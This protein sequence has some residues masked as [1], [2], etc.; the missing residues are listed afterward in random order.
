[1][2]MNYQKLIDFI[3]RRQ[4]L[5]LWSAIILYF[6]VFS[7]ICL[8]KYYH[9]GYNGLDLAIY[10]QVFYNSAHGRLFEFS[11][12]PQSYLGD[13]FELIII[14]LLPF[15]YF[16]QHPVNLL[17]IQSLML[18]LCA[19]PLY[20]IAKKFLSVRWSLF[21]AWAWLLCPFVQN[22]NLFEFHILP[23][24]IF[25][26]LWAWYF[27][28]KNN[29]PAFIALCLISLLVREDVALVVF[30]FGL[31]AWLEKRPWRWIIWPMFSSAAWFVFATTMVSRL[32]PSGSY[33]FLAYYAWLGGD[34]KE[35]AVNFFTKP[36]L[37][38]Q[39]FVCLNNLLFI[40]ALLLPFGFIFLHPVYLLL[41]LLIFLQLAIGGSN[42]SLIVLKTHYSSL[43]VFSMFIGYIY[44]LK[45]LLAGKAGRLK[46]FLLK[47]KFLLILILSVAVIYSAMALGPL[48]GFVKAALN[49][50]AYQKQ[51]NQ[52]KTEFYHGVPPADSVAA[53]Y[54]S[55]TVLSSRPRLYSLHYAYIGKKQ[56]STLDYRLPEDVKTL[57][58]D[59]N[60]LLVYSVQFP[61]SSQ[62]QLYYPEGDNR[63]RRI[64]EQG[65][66]GVVKIADNLVKMEK[67]AVADIPLY[68]I[69]D[70]D[71]AIPNKQN[72]RYDNGLNFLGWSADTIITEGQSRLLPLSVSFKTA[73]KLAKDYQLKIGFKNTAGEI[74]HQKYYPLAYGL[75]PTT[76]WLPEEIVKTNYY[77]LIPPEIWTDG[78]TI[79]LQ[80]VYLN[81]FLILDGL[82][83]A[84]P[85]VSEEDPLLPVVNVGPFNN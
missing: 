39:R 50:D 42:N 65:K 3:N 62:W 64:L 52:L 46:K 53:S 1:M 25:T 38:L 67:G 69:L 20:L 12:H 13:H 11:I 60:D 14:A 36:L 78:F 9:F 70:S 79:D 83:T 30:M 57:M 19:W 72:I 21:V 84:V 31:I 59:F 77:L 10:N 81:G 28:L 15:Y 74:I 29:F 37:V 17:I 54:E 45:K 82:R 22:I 2:A 16:F 61:N 51:L 23:F 24:A 43:L 7:F 27:Y 6:L 4:R 48:P 18:A 80:P 40:L 63:L 56:F 26:L 71:S 35:M 47:E 49:N 85:N 44:G 5:L 76:E 41:G 33:K 8:W 66:Y 58:F 55:L 34:L 32:T 68:Q 75:Y 73:K